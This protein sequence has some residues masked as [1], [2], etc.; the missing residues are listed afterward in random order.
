MLTRLPSGYRHAGEGP[1]GGNPL[2]AEV[3]WDDLN[4]PK[5]YKFDV[6]WDTP[7]KAYRLARGEEGHRRPLSAGCILFDKDTGAFCSYWVDDISERVNLWHLPFPFETGT[8]STVCH[9]LDPEW[10]DQKTGKPYV[11]SVNEPTCA[12]CHNWL[13]PGDLRSRPAVR[14]VDAS[15]YNIAP[16]QAY[17]SPECRYKAQLERQK[18]R[19]HCNKANRGKVTFGEWL[20]KGC[21]LIPKIRA[22]EMDN[23]SSP[24]PI[25]AL[26]RLS[27]SVRSVS[28]SSSLL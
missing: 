5:K 6:P 26:I 4:L 8:H 11:S 10:V 2:P 27:T 1:G 7:V 18:R 22:A 21:P 13:L 3:F 15:Y 20:D 14:T 23:P 17:C 24:S 9:R 16:R 25:N 19:Y 12:Y 28:P